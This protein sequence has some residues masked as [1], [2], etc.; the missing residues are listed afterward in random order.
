MADIYFNVKGTWHSEQGDVMNILRIGYSLGQ[1]DEDSKKPPFWFSRI[2]THG[3]KSG[4][5]RNF[6]NKISYGKTYADSEATSDE[7]KSYKQMM[8]NLIKEVM[9]DIKDK[10]K[11][12]KKPFGGRWVR[13]LYKKK[14]GFTD[15]INTYSYERLNS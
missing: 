3:T 9:E 7:H 6:E 10:D 2:Y 13:G 15:T 5:E 4:L 11:E 14:Y 12:F 1:I 8:A